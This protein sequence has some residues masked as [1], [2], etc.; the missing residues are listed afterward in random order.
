VP[1]A[2]SRKVPGVRQVVVKRKQTLA[3]G[4]TRITPCTYW[5]ADLN[6]GLDANG[7]RKRKLVYCSTQTEA[8]EVLRDNL[9]KRPPKKAPVGKPQTVAAYL[10]NW[11]IEVA[12]NISPS[13]LR[14]Y[15]GTI[16]GH[17]MKHIDGIQLANFDGDQV[18]ILYRKLVDV[19]TS[20]SMRQ[21]IHTVLR[22]ALN[23]AVAERAL[24]VSPLVGIK[25]PRHRARPMSALTESQARDFL[26]AAAEHRL[27]GLFVLAVATGMR[28]GELFSLLV[29]DVDIPNRTIIVRQSLEELNGKLR[30]KGT[31]SERVREIKMGSLEAEA[32]ERRL[33]L[34][35]KE[36]HHSPYCFTSP[37]GMLLRKSNF[38]RNTYAKIREN[39]GLPSS[40]RF[41]DLRH[42][43]FSFDMKNGVNPK[44]IQE[45]AGHADVST[46]LRVYGHTS[47][48]L[49]AEAAD[50]MSALLRPR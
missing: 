49:H 37:R 22:I 24:P 36:G 46:T 35:K 40:V 44:V 18:K 21:R 41:H 4:T 20:P 12:D 23:S 29:D 30:V 42:T 48:A 27:E 32:M 7:K 45:K 1:R 25:S 38:Y 5:R 13:T 8:V 26:A 34:A 2:G 43:S 50:K 33:V 19:G 6:L 10:A 17:V 9:V 16:E 14:S 47:P 28:E 31:K 39:A 3:D 11:L 15:K